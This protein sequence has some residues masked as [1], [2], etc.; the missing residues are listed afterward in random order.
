MEALVNAASEFLAALFARFGYVGRPR[1]RAAIR[2]EILLLGEIRDSPDFGVESKAHRFLADHVTSEVARYSGV[3]LKR[4]RKIPWSS[5]FI[6]LLIGL[7]LA[8]WTYKLN[9]DGFAW[10]SILPGFLAALMLLAVMGMLFG[11]SGS[12]E[13][14]PDQAA[15]AEGS[16]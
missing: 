13:E 2:D 11:E 10:F 6:A 15:H 9:E 7:P 1:R 12:T 5:V 3:E 4:K 8:Y 16:T 14:E